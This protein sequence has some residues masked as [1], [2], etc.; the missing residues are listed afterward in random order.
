VLVPVSTGSVIDTA[1]C[2][3]LQRFPLDNFAD[4]QILRVFLDVFP[5][6]LNKRRTQGSMEWLSCFSP[7]VLTWLAQIQRD[8]EKKEAEDKESAKWFLLFF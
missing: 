2:T 1:N 7:V 3:A 5:G 6:E 8:K 4:V